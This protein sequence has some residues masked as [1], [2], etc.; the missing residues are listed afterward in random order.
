[1]AEAVVKAHIESYRYP[2]GREL[3]LAAINVTIRQG[4]FVLIA[5]PSGG[6]KSTLC[7]CLCGLIPHFYGGD[8]IG[9]IEVFGQDTL[10]THPHDLVPHLGVVFQNPQDQLLAVTVQDDVAF[11]PQQLSLQRAEIQQRVEEALTAVG[12]ANLRDRSV[13]DLSSGQQQRVA[14]AGA[15]ALQP[16][17][18]ILDEP[19][20]QIDPKGAAAFLDSVARLHKQCQ[21]T[22][23]MVEHRLAHVLPVADRLIVIANGRIAWDGEPRQGLA[24]VSLADLGLAIPPV[25]QLALDLRKG[26]ILLDPLPLTVDEV[27]AALDRV[28]GSHVARR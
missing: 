8:L 21:T 15:L 5:G 9:T 11:G 16:D 19:T 14:L 22:I 7:R 13:F 6:G 4:E 17:L 3:A 20:S 10:A 27:A 12:I 26:G 2:G 1:M 24:E 25:V 28:W 23:I 18:L